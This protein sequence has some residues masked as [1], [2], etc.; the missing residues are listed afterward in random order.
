M[1][2]SVTEYDQF[3]NTSK[4]TT[5]SPVFNTV[6][7][8][9]IVI[10]AVNGGKLTDMGADPGG[11]SAS[12][13]WPDGAWHLLAQVDAGVGLPKIRA[14]ATQFI[15]TASRKIRLMNAS[16]SDAHQYL[17][18]IDGMRPGVDPAQV[19]DVGAASSATAGTS[20]AVP[21]YSPDG[22]GL[23]IGA[24]INDA[25]ANY[26]SLGGLTARTELDGGSST[27]RTGE[28]TISASGTG[29][30]TATCS[31]GAA[32]AA[33]SIAIRADAGASVTF[34]QTPL[35]MRVEMAPGANPGSDPATWAGLWTD[36]SDDVNMRD[37]ITI[38]RGRQDES[39]TASPS[40]MTLTLNNASGTYV[41]LNPLS[42]Y[43]GSLR[44]N[45]PLRLWV[46][47]GA[48]DELRYTGFVSEFPPR[49]RGG[50]VDEHMPLQ[51]DGPM[52]RLARGQV[53][54]SALR[55]AILAGVIG[56]YTGYWPL[57]TDASSAIAGQANMRLTG[58]VTFGD[59]GPSG[60][61]G[62][63]STATSATAYAPVVGMPNGGGWTVAW[64]IDIPDGF[65]TASDVSIMVNWTT[66]GS[67][68]TRW[69]AY[70]NSS[71]PGH[72][73][74]G[75]F[76]PSIGQFAV[77]GQVNLVNAGPC[78]IIIRARNEGSDIR[79]GVEAIGDG[80]DDGWDSFVT[81]DQTS[82]ITGIGI[83]GY[84]QDPPQEPK[85]TV[86]HL[87][88]SPDHPLTNDFSANLTAGFGYTGETA[89]DR[90]TRVSSEEGVSVAI[91]G[92]AGQSEA[93]GP[94]P[95]ASYLDILRDCEN[96]DGGLLYERRDGRLAYQTRAAR[97]NATT[98]LT[99]ADMAAIA[100]PLEPTDDDQ[101][102]AND[103]T[104]SR[105]GG[106]SA[107]AFDQD[108]IDAV[109][110]Y[111]SSGSVNVESDEQLPHQA[112]WR[113]HLG[114]ADGLRFPTIV[115]NLN[116][117]PALIPDWVALDVGQPATLT[118]PSRDLPPGPIDLVVE[119]YTE[120]LD[121]VSWA[122][123]ANC[124]P[125]APWKVVQL[126][127]AVLGRL[128]TDG[129]QL[130]SSITSSDTT[131]SVATTS[132]PLWTTDE[133]DLP[134]DLT[135]GGE[136]VT[137]TA[138]GQTLN[139]NPYFTV[140]ASGWSGFNATVARSTAQAP[141]TGPA[142]VAL[143]TPDGVNATGG[144]NSSATAVGT[145]TPGQSYT[146][147]LWVYSPAGWS[148]IR[149]GID[150]QTS[151]GTL[152]SNAFAPQG[153]APAGQWVRLSATLVAPATSSKAVVRGRHAG[154]P[155]AGDIW[156]AW[157][158]RLIPAGS[159]QQMTVTRSVNGITKSHS[160]GE[161]VALAQTPILAQ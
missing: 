31:A 158:I 9:L 122:A 18:Y 10:H 44:K 92:D 27:S 25:V 132:G 72:M 46:N 34:P 145:I 68:Y 40:S 7:T 101:H 113:V 78:L 36:I 121:V 20:Q 74:V 57:E 55:R 129:A 64:W 50:Q 139:S 41:R 63:V 157:G 99:L 42:P 141:P 49:S 119:G 104:A 91:I 32:W 37:L 115:P 26:T 108:H 112:G 80:F 107:R 85:G 84:Q 159:P 11:D 75:V 35:S 86:S 114:T 79:F 105:D 12:G 147:V 102:L 98:R 126:D 87:V 144:I 89:A 33:V 13:T 97:Y 66:P 6:G 60:S 4:G 8:W 146:A 118:S 22:T 70:L 94:Q 1:A 135:V 48:G 54:N 151:G 149:P 100:P 124:S 39:S 17:Y 53:L 150:W 160:S 127:D 30:R 56:N 21:L 59:G 77:N 153:G 110:Q 96:A 58:N 154:T 19:F 106:G 123:E 161:A 5:W 138:I 93:M 29:T 111:A 3:V 14:W 15:D 28:Q 130:A 116:G 120:T 88:V 45:T 43:Y 82:P 155:T 134:V 136:Q 109:G 142:G 156:Y 51:A 65:D 61:A 62:A 143:V 90:I 24:W 71:S 83:N 81:G 69:L 103:Y 23:L 117:Q 2:V 76:E 95:V 128:D 38:S 152:I 125:G 67:T 47:A 133:T 140:D 16:A 73:I 131:L 52:R 148:D 137:A